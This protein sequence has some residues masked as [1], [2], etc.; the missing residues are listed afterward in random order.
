MELQILERLKRK[1]KHN[2]A[3]QDLEDHFRLSYRE[4]DEAN[5]GSYFFLSSSVLHFCFRLL[6]AVWD[7]FI[8]YFFLIS[9]FAF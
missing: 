6:Y 1:R 7:L 5:P 9:F 3:M 4:I 8:S 2:E